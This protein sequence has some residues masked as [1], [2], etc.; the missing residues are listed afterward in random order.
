MPARGTGCLLV[1]PFDSCDNDPEAPL[2]LVPA[3]SS[4]RRPRPCT[5]SAPGAR[6]A[7]RC[8]PR[9]HAGESASC[10]PPGGCICNSPTPLSAVC[11]ALPGSPRQ[12]PCL[13]PVLPPGRVEAP[14][15]GR[16][17]VCASHPSQVS[18]E[19]V[20]CVYGTEC[21]PPR[22]GVEIEEVQCH[23]NFTSGL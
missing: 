14:A 2:H 13:T 22:R 17:P 3:Q 18:K 20:T 23:L 4:L 16:A 6:Q 12:G 21:S 11:R 8:T 15:P 7:A 10:Y 19:H 5:G 9:L 1:A